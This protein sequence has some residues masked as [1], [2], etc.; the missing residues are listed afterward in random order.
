MLLEGLDPS[1]FDRNDD[2]NYASKVLMATVN[3]DV[4]DTWKNIV[5]IVLGYS[6]YVACCSFVLFNETEQS[7]R[8]N[9]IV[10]VCD[11]VNF[12]VVSCTNSNAGRSKIFI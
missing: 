2:S 4:H 12:V 7:R 9:N 10:F 6:N 8:Q 5:A 11:V 1:T 3:N